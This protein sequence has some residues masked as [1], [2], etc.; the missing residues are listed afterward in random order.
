MS[1]AAVEWK[2]DNKLPVPVGNEF[3][4]LEDVSF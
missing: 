3:I 4:V 1:A 2:W